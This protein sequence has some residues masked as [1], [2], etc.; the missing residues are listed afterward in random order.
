MHCAHG[1]VLIILLCDY[2]SQSPPTRLLRAQLAGVRVDGM[3]LEG[4]CKLLEDG[5]CG[6]GRT[7]EPEPYTCER[8]AVVR[9]GFRALTTPTVAMTFDFDTPEV[10]ILYIIR[11]NLILLSTK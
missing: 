4:S 2:L 5:C 3:V 9:N 7:L 10:F 8:L 6:A 1:H 11:Q